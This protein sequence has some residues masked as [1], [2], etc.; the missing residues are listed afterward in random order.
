[1]RYMSLS[2]VDKENKYCKKKNRNIN[3]SDQQILRCSKNQNSKD[4]LH[5]TIN[6]NP[7]DVT[8]KQ[9]DFVKLKQSLAGQIMIMI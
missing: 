9:K 8:K 1:M 7:K 2:L 6:T 4:I 3:K 5:I